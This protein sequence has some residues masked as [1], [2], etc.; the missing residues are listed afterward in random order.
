MHYLWFAF[1]CILIRSHPPFYPDTPIIATTLNMLHSAFARF[2][3]AVLDIFNLIISDSNSS[4]NI[5]R[6]YKTH[7]NGTP[8]RALCGK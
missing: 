6:D 8:D 5:S 1:V 2:V 7:N 3:V 4:I